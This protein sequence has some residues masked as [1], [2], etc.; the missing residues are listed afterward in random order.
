MISVLYVDDESALL[1]VTKDFM[2]R[3]GEFKV[4]TAI[5]AREA[6][7]KLKAE[8][9]DALVAD[10]L[11]PEMDGL[12]LLKYLRPRC[13][14]MPFIIFTGKGDEE[15]AIDALNSGADFYIQKKGSP[16]TQFAELETKI[17]SAVARRQ[18]E[19]ILRQS[20]QDLRSLVEHLT[21]VVF[22]I[23]E[24]GIISYISPP[25]NR[26]GYDPKDLIGKDFAILVGS[27][28]IPAVARHFA[29]MK[30]NISASFEFRLA[31]TNGQLHFVYAS[32]SPRIDNGKFSGGQGLL[33]DITSAKED[34]E[35]VRRI[36][37]QHQMVFDLSPDGLIIIDPETGVP[38]EFNDEVCRQ[39]GYSHEE[40]SGLSLYD[41]EISEGSQKL[42]EK[43]P[44]ILQKGSITLETRYRT[45]EGTIRDV[46]VTARVIDDG[47]LKKIGLIIHD[48]T[49]EQKQKKI[50]EE[51]ALGSEAIFNQAPLAQL[52]L[53]M[54]GTVTGINQAGTEIFSRTADEILGKSLA[55]FIE[56]NDRE[57]F[58]RTLEDLVRSGRIHEAPFSLVSQDNKSLNVSIDGSTTSTNNGKIRQLLVTLTDITEQVK[59]N[60]ELE[61]A[62]ISATG[63]IAGAREGIFVCN[64]D[65]VITAWNP[66]MEDITGTASHDAIGHHLADMLLFLKETGGADSPASRALTGE[67]V[68]TP[69]SRYEYPTTSKGGWV[70]A[71]F[72]PLR[73]PPGKIQGIIGVVQE[74]T[75]RTKTLLSIKAANQVFSISAY[76]S[77]KAPV[78]HD[79]PMLL[80]ET[81][82][83]AIDSDVINSAWIGL[84]D[85]AAGVLRPVAHAGAGEGLGKEGFPV[86]A[87]PE[88][89]LVKEAIRTGEPAVCSDTETDLAA[90][91][92]RDATQSAGYRSLAVIPFRFNG[93]VVGVIAL[94]SG[95]PF[96]F[97]KEDTN[98]LSHLGT[99]LSQALD[100]LDKKTLQRRAGRGGHGSWERTRFLAGGIESGAIPFATIQADGTLW[101]V[102]AKFCTLLGYT[103][104]ELLA[105]P[106][107]Q[108]FNSLSVDRCMQVLLTKTPEHF[109][110]TVRKKDGSDLPVELFLQEIPDDT[111]DQMCVGVFIT[112]FSERKQLIENLKTDRQKYYTFFEKMCAAVVIS[113]P[114]GTILTAN[115]AACQLLGRTKEELCS[116]GG[117]LAGAGDPRFIELADRAGKTA[118]QKLNCDW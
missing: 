8:R 21:D 103:E 1:E 24:E 37:N 54:E 88:S 39:L 93:K 17:R 25:I 96:A 57:R 62:A 60:A 47:T 48:V 20:E 118:A 110:T 111:S 55:G 109:E 61:T 113:A 19:Q 85:Q 53:T 87:D 95:Q 94:C 23:S 78:V 115:P 77:T 63:V 101:A 27:E 29:Y 114:D 71:I 73:D 43:I 105:L 107:P 69:D 34:T 11:M 28:D 7:E 99:S 70:R 76:V 91:L 64:Q 16:R 35:Q 92:F 89:D 44:D 32:L 52:T 90:Q 65:Q 26:F 9:Y 106:L 22:T 38:V 66:A 82:Q 40:F 51:K 112:D 108:I 75:A 84:F 6:I 14:G 56:N 80:S 41:V 100:L 97:S 50:L 30:Q 10:Y 116:E 98:V 68:A 45:K 46:V 72:S 42:S 67:I 74:I 81:C 5:S 3:G 104:D 15:T 83:I 58:A 18:S 59:K 49:E 13:N 86:T 33:A 36:I 31:D 102:N 4:D 2:E 12:E 117:G 79:L